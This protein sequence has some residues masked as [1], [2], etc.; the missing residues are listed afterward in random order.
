[1]L[2]ITA[3]PTG[4]SGPFAGLLCAGAN[5]RAS[6]AMANGRFDFKYQ[7]PGSPFPYLPSYFC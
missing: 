2:G 1:M 6:L 4:S 7:P 3:S 5:G